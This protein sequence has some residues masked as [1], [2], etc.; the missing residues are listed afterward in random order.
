MTNRYTPGGRRKPAL[1]LVVTVLITAVSTDTIAALADG[2]AGL[3][4]AR[5]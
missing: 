4:T 3:Q 1:R 5:D 2:F